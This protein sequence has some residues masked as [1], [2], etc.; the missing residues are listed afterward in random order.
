L[1][2]SQGIPAR[3][4][5]RLQ[6]RYVKHFTHVLT[7]RAMISIDIPGTWYRVSTS[8]GTLLPEEFSMMPAAM[9]NGCSY[10]ANSRNNVM[11]AIMQVDT[12]ARGTHDLIASDRVEG[13]L[14]RGADGTRIGTIDRVMIDKLTGTVAYAVLSV[15]DS[16]GMGQKH[17]PIAWQRLK[18]DRKLG[19]YHLELT[20]VELTSTRDF[21]WGDRGREIEIDNPYGVKPYWGIAEGL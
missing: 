12:T 9:Q 13:T 16:V 19:A 15:N 21:D 8:Q 4:A 3:Q 7:K 14:V 2:Q 20:E 1:G 10:S 5:N 18:Y 11:E 6:A 17:V